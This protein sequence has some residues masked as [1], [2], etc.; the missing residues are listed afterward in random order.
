MHLATPQNQKLLSIPDGIAGIRAT[1]A[2]MTAY[3]REYKKAPE[4]RRLAGL[5]TQN[6]PGKDFRA[7]VAALFDYVQHDIRYLLDI[8][9]VETLQT[10]LVTLENGSGDCDDKSTLLAALLESIGHKTR[11]LAASYGGDVEHVFVETMIGSSWVA[12]DA[13][14]PHPMGWRTPGITKEYYSHN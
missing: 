13:T 8:A 2:H 5:L 6:L 1:L 7:E 3:V 12:L 14:E 4:I 9:D 10:P 11:F